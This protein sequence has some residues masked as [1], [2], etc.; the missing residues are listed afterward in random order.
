MITILICLSTEKKYLQNAWTTL[1][2]RLATYSKYVSLKMHNMLSDVPLVLLV[3]LRMYCMHMHALEMSKS[4]KSSTVHF[5]CFQTNKICSFK[6]LPK[7]TSQSQTAFT[8]T[9]RQRRYLL[10]TTRHCKANRKLFKDNYFI[11]L[12][13]RCFNS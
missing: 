5:R 1:L 9:P 4:L 11:N 2:N 3:V 12:E 8:F 13:V 6:L 7:Q 10:R